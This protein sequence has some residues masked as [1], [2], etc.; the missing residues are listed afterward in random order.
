MIGLDAA[1]RQLIEILMTE[2]RLPTL[3][4]LSEQGERGR[5]LPLPGLGDDAVW[6]SFATG[7]GPGVHGRFYHMRFELERFV[8][9]PR[10]VVLRSPFWEELAD[11]GLRVAV[12]DVPKSPVG[13]IGNGVLIADWMCHG[14]DHINMTR[15]L[16]RS[17]VIS[18]ELSRRQVPMRSSSSFRS[19]EWVPTIRV[20]I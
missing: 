7:V 15:K 16:Q 19:L 3:K 6:T 13:R 10:D 17:M 4:R 5:L 11:R 9:H 1:D 12:I 8:P 20:H 18:K 2:G 14:P